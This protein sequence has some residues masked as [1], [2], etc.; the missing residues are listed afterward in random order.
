MIFFP[1]DFL[2]GAACASY[3]CEGVW[4]E[5]G[6]GP[7]IWDDFCHEYKGHRIRHDETGDMACDFYHRYR[8]DIALM[9]AHG[10]QAFR[11]SISWAR[12]YPDA[13]GRVNG[14][15]V[16]FYQDVCDELLHSGI[17]PMVTL[18]HWDLPSWIQERGGWQNRQIV[19]W[20]GVYA[21][22]MAEALKGRVRKYM[23]VNEP[24]CIAN[25]GHGIGVFAPGYKLD[26][27]KLVRIFHYVALCHSEA[28]RQ[29]KAV[30][31]SAQVGLA[32][33]GRMLYPEK[34]TPE[35]REAV[36]RRT[37]DLHENWTEGYNT[38]PD[39][40]IFRRWDPS[41]PEGVRRF[42]DTIPSSDWEAMEKPDFLGVNLYG[43]G[44][45]DEAGNDIPF[46]TGGPRTAN[47]WPI[48]PEIMHYGIAA[49]YRRYGLPI[50]ITENGISCNDRVFLDGKVHD[51]ER[52][53]FLH[54][55]LTEL[56]KAIQEGVPVKGYLQWSIMDNFE[57]ASG[58]E[59]R[60][61]LVYID[62]QTLE[63][64]PKDSFAWY[65]QVIKS[66]G[67]SLNEIP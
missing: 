56:Y 26:V 5:D 58:Y 17:E 23:T 64:I 20:F 44:M 48:T 2:W 63:R 1:D 43:G 19:E 25:N 55:Y 50:Y 42:A 66:N 51:P 41:I 61:G 52:I 12:I 14:A 28:Q 34:D 18:Y 33:N 4:N 22:T 59:E 21:R 49:I 35:N 38:V 30:D 53:D 29:I 67:T 24:M 27:E 9:K 10:I 45:V 54:R 40:L 3:Q 8:E 7:N 60:F 65:K 16:Q 37:F 6:K 15:G 39:S 13:S 36:Y 47:R 46:P 57:W 32:C 31:P 62:Y 11:F